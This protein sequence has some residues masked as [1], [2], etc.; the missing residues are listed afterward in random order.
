MMQIYEKSVIPG[1]SHYITLYLNQKYDKIFG[2]YYK[3]S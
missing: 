3:L 2:L 1:H